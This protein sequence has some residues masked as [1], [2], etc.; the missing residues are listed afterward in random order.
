FAELRRFGRYRIYKDN[1][2][3]MT[4]IFR[5]HPNPPKIR[6]IH[7]AFKSNLDELPKMVEYTNEHGCAS[8]NEIRYTFNFAHIT[9]EFRRKHYLERAD[10]DTLDN[11]LA[12]LPDANVRIERPPLDHEELILPTT[13]FD[14]L[15]TPADALPLIPPDKVPLMLRAR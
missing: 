14:R 10:W 4:A 6:Y 3:R 1:L 7:M 13:H 12:A 15:R 5:S 8:E 9:D 11:M 2:D